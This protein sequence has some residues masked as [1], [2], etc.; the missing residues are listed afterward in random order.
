MVWTLFVL[1]LDRTYDMED[2]FSN[3]VQPLVYLIP[4]D[5]QRDVEHYARMA[6]NDF[7]TN[8]NVEEWAIA[9]C[10]EEWMRN[11]NCDFKV[12]GTIDLTFI[13]RQV[14]YLADYIHREIV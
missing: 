3:G 9:D 1:D 5:R 6:H 12:V 2:D 4:L 10:F 13:E 8:K 11:N 14:D 7:H